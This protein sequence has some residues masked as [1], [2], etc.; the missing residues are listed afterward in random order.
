MRQAV[1]CAFRSFYPEVWQH[2]PDLERAADLASRSAD[3][4]Q[5]AF[6][7]QAGWTPFPGTGGSPV[8]ELVAYHYPGQ[9][10]RL[11]TA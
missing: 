11:W 1:M 6:I 7:P 5:A 2:R 4:R 10:N 8:L 9:E 3:I